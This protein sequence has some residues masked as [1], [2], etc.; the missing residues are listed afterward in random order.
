[1]SAEEK[2]ILAIR[3][4]LIEKHGEEFLTLSEEEQNELIAG[5][6]TDY[7]ETLKAAQ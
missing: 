5:T 7:I 3:D 1:M 4:A 2:I 6:M